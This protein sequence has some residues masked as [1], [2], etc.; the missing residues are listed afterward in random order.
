MDLAALMSRMEDDDEPGLTNDQI[1]TRLEEYHALV[2]GQEP[3]TFT[4]GQIV[5][6]KMGK[7]ADTRG[8]EHPHI[9]IGYLP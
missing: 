5:W 9:F 8:S 1:A 3:E 6:H 7:A 2:H 4:P